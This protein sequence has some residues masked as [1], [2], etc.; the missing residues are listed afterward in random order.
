MPCGAGSVALLA[1]INV[2]RMCAAS[3]YY[4]LTKMR[5][6]LLSLTNAV[7][8]HARSMV[9]HP[10]ESRARSRVR[11]RYNTCISRCGEQSP[12]FSTLLCLAFFVH[13][14]SINLLRLPTST[15][16]IFPLGIGYFVDRK[17][18]ITMNSKPHGTVRSTIHVTAFFSCV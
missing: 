17:E 15:V 6:R 5:T 10:L 16:H 14:G 8:A 3:F 13:V 1:R 4:V 11:Q 2:C 9:P 18:I 12:A 7:R